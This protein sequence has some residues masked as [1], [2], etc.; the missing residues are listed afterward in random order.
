M[1]SYFD[2]LNTYDSNMIHLT[3]DGDHSFWLVSPGSIIKKRL[4]EYGFEIDL[5]ENVDSPGCYFID[6]NADPQWWAGVLNDVGAPTAHIIDLIPTHIKDLVRKKLLRIVIAGDKE[7]GVFVTDKFDCYKS[8]TEAMIRSSLPAGAVLILH[9]NMKAE[10]QYIQWLADTQSPKL[11]EIMY[12]NT[13]LKVFLDANVPTEPIVNQSIVNSDAKDYNSLNRVFRPH[14]GAHLYKIAKDSIL[15]NGLVSA[16][17]IFEDIT[18]VK[19]SN[20][21]DYYTVMSANY[22]KFID[23]NWSNV[24]AGP[25]YNIDIYKNSLISFVTETKFDEPSV[26]PTEKIYKPLMLGHPIILLAAAGTLEGIRSLG[27]KTDWCGIDSSYNDIE[28]DVLRL[29][30]THE[31]LLNW[32]HLS[33][34][35]KIKRIQESMPTISHNFNLA[36]T[37]NFHK[38][39]LQEALNRS[40]RY[41]ND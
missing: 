15:N 19:L 37:S 29:Q 39:S 36:R 22:P 26:F 33:R 38:D 13:F 11:F 14:R 8:T 21:L 18:A 30:A 40:K 28:D 27:F 6:V 41:F 20:G 3:S 34:K 35:E 10:S 9:G 31:S 32:V 16:N 24:N 1:K 17:E 2:N 4:T 7:G 12:S 25:Q 23:G 5:V